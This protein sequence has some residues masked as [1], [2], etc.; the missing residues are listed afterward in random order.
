MALQPDLKKDPPNRRLARYVGGI[1]LARMA[2]QDW[3]AGLAAAA[4]RFPP[5]LRE[6]FVY[7]PCRAYLYGLRRIAWARVADLPLT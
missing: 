4:G 1:A 7:R 3:R 6:L 5:K 2:R